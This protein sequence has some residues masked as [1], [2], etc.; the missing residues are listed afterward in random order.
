[1]ILKT[2][3]NNAEYVPLGSFKV[4]WFAHNDRHP[5]PVVSLADI[6]AIFGAG[7]KREFDKKLSKLGERFGEMIEYMVQP[8]M[9][10]RFRELGLFF[11]MISSQTSH[12]TEGNRVLAE[13]DVFLEN[14]E[15][16]MVVEIKSKPSIDDIKEHIERMEKTRIWADGRGD[17]RKF[18]G[19]IGGMIVNDNER[20]F[21]LK[22]GFYVIE[23]SGE[24]FIITAPEGNYSPREW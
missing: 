16:A 12:T 8:N 3:V 2:L 20:N 23:P 10:R 17:G 15:M 21:A 14:R 4:T 22:S 18:L 1:M 5:K 7:Q 6:Y 19:A 13:V 11:D 9:L 24:T